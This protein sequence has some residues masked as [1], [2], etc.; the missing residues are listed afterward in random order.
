MNPS[1][2][3]TEGLRQPGLPALGLAEDVLPAV[4]RSARRPEPSLPAP[5]AELT[6]AAASEHPVRMAPG[7]GSSLA[8]FLGS[9]PGRQEHDDAE[10]IEA[11]VQMVG[12]EL[13]GELYGIEIHLVQE[14]IRVGTVTR[15]PGAP[16]PILGITS[17]R[18]KILPVLDLRIRL[19]L[20]AAEVGARSRIVVADLGGKLLGLLVDAVHQVL[21]LPPSS[22][23][24][25]PDGGD[26]VGGV[27]Q[28]AGG[29]LIILLELE[30][31][32][33]AP[34][35]AGRGNPRPEVHD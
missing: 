2:T 12:V 6:K 21:P 22:I 5:G 29:R 18:G 17:L 23:E 26:L 20:P 14:V 34:A 28:L 13:L 11:P 32:L 19:G 27:A 16:R 7:S 30:G 35:P 25:P 3:G 33:A 8:E 15:V 31:L 10:A 4:R 1:S 24:P 9:L